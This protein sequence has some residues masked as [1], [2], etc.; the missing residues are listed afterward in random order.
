M[1]NLIFFW[2]SPVISN[3]YLKALLSPHTQHIQNNHLHLFLP[4]AVPFHLLYFCSRYYH[5]SNL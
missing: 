3:S 4:D 2:S 5:S 1:K